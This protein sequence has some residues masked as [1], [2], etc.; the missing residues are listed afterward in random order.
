[1]LLEVVTLLMCITYIL[2]SKSLNK[3]YIGSTRGTMDDRICKH[4]TNH[5][6]FTGKAKDWEIV[7]M[8]Q[9]DYYEQALAKEKLIKGWKSRKMLEKLIILSKV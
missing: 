5:D 8:E 2:Y 9:F 6:G 1:M 3:F 7:F 4:L